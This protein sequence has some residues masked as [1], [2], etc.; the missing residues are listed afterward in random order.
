MGSTD[1]KKT[2]NPQ[3]E[4]G[5]IRI[6]TELFEQLYQIPLNG[7]QI[8]I[9]LFVIRNTYGFNRK[10]WKM[11]AGY[12]A[13]GTG[14]SMSMVKREIKKLENCNIL[15][16]SHAGIGKI[17]SIG[18][19]KKYSE[20]MIK[21][22]HN[23]TPCTIVHHAGVQHDT[24]TGTQ[25]DTGTG[26]QYD[27]QH[28]TDKHNTEN[29]RQEEEKELSLRSLPSDWKTLIPEAE[30]SEEYQKLKL[31]NGTYLDPREVDWERL[32]E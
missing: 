19:N 11:S 29:I 9:V 28:N 10:T 13:R 14:I 22:V 18:I 8:R 17:G 2:G 3:V 32:R 31:P 25:Y 26:A 21:P 4:N 15:K 16:V 30:I 12:I 6:A 20:W 1:K 7:S 24:G 27:P 23:M 5:Y